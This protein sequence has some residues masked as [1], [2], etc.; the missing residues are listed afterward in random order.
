MVVLCFREFYYTLDFIDNGSSEALDFTMTSNY[1]NDTCQAGDS[2]MITGELE[3]YDEELT[4]SN[5]CTT[6]QVVSGS[7]YGTWNA[8]GGPFDFCKFLNVMSIDDKEDGSS[9]SSECPSPGK[10]TFTTH[11]QVI[12]ASSEG[13]CF[14]FI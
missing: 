14:F 13:E 3:I 1:C 11:L 10:Y 6:L 5:I 8:M 4:T 9:S 12:T 2:I 7:V